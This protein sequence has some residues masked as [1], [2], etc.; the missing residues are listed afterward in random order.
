MDERKI[1]QKISEGLEKLNIDNMQSDEYKRGF[2]DCMKL[3]WDIFDI[4]Y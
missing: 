3:I 2:N 1:E 4:E